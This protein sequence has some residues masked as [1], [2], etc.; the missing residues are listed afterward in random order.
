MPDQRPS[1]RIACASGFSGD[2]TDVA[3]PVVAE[4]AA[5][6]GG[7]LIFET[8]AE[9]TLAL[10]QLSSDADPER[11]YEPL[12]DDLVSPVLGDCLAHYISIVSN[13]SLIH[14]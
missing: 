12:L 14:I 5:G 3:A 9:R 10:A 2:R 4:L 7:T 11:G 13:L 1:I 8:L 6:G